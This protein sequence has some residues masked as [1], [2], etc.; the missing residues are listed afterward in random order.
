M[1]SNS[2][3][4]QQPEDVKRA[5][6]II[7]HWAGPAVMSTV[8]GLLQTAALQGP[9][10]PPPSDDAPGIVPPPPPSGAVVDLDVE[11]L[12][13]DERI[14]AGSKEKNAD[15]RWKS[16]KGVKR[17]SPEY[18]A[19]VAQLRLIYPAP[20]TVTPPPPP[21]ADV[22]DVPAPPPPPPGGMDFPG[23]MRRVSKLIAAKKLT[24]AD[25]NSIAQDVGLQASHELAQH[26]D[27]VPL[28]NDMLTVRVGPD[29]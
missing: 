18:A 22:A 14:H 1:Q 19:A 2:T 26:P 12:P 21:P 5:I 29:A 23:L 10:P 8:A 17:E 9:P 13:W 16:R 4:I 28:F 27:K 20:A 7:G 3:P 11:G 6:A 24:P 15:G 25:L